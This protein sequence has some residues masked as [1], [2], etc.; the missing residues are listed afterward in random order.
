MRAQGWLRPVVGRKKQDL[1]D[2]LRRY[3]SKSSVVWSGGNGK[4]AGSRWVIFTSCNTTA[5]RYFDFYLGGCEQQ[6]EPGLSRVE[7]ILERYTCT[8]RGPSQSSWGELF[9]SPQGGC[10]DFE[11]TKGDASRPRSKKQ[12]GGFL[13]SDFKK[14]I[15]VVVHLFCLQFSKKKK[16][17]KKKKKNTGEVLPKVD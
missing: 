14:T 6:K 1:K 5:G 3:Q 15:A 10:T 13:P 9:E 4:L 17:K 2:A 12:S 11:V 16:K 7:I 8:S